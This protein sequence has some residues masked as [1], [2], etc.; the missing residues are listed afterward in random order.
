MPIVPSPIPSTAHVSSPRMTR[1]LRSV[2]RGVTLLELLV[3]LILLAVTAAVVLPTFMPPSTTA[4]ADPT[5]TVVASARRVAIRRGEPLRLRIAND[6]VWALVTLHDGAAVDA[7]R[8]KSVKHS[9]DDAPTVSTGLVLTID[10]LGS[11]QPDHGSAAGATYDP[12][13]CR[14]SNAM[15][16][17]AVL[18]TRGVR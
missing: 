7:G 14:W 1:S 18:P 17:T 13:T 9:A 10:A 5:A 2:R 6:G 11:C 8:V 12:L 3:V 16:P 4:D 15:K